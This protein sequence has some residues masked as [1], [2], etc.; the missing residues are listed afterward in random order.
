VLASASSTAVYLGGTYNGSYDLAGII[1]PTLINQGFA[2]A[3]VRLGA[4][5][6]ANVIAASKSEMTKVPLS[7]FPLPASTGNGF[8]V[9]F[10]ARATAL[11]LIN[12]VG[13]LV[14][15]QYPSAGARQCTVP[16]AGWAPGR[17]TLQ[18]LGENY[19]STR[20]VVIE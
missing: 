17:Y 19:I 1:M 8:E 4:M 15:T 11:H 18:V 20:A 12:S 16:T 3:F 10:S 9:Y 5:P 7:V 14:H 6:V 2:S 13:Q